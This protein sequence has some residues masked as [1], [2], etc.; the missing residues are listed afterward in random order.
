MEADALS[1]IDWEKDEKTLPADSIQAIVTAA[2]TGQG[3]DYIGTIPCSPQIIESLPHIHDNAQIVCKSITMTETK[4]NLDCSICPDPSWNPK[5]MTMLDW[6]KVQA[7]DQVIC[8]LIQWYKSRELHR[9]KD[10]DSLDM[11]Q[12]LKQEGKVL[13]RNEILYCKND[14]KETECPDRN[15][16]QII[17][18]TTLRIQALRGCYDDLRHLGLERTLDLLRD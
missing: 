13:L 3:N 12:F 8:N 14:T 9:G 2:L 18:P 17:L 15:T 5:C 6:V 16:M 1:R 11:K 4:L 10:T 7:E